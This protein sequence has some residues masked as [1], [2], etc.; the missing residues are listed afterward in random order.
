ML[1]R[2]TKEIG[3]HQKGASTVYKQCG[4]NHIIKYAEAKMFSKKSAVK[5]NCPNKDHHKPENK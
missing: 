2:K 3:D 1:R 5:G 4:R